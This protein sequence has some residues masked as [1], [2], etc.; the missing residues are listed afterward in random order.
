MVN[1]TQASAQMSIKSQTAAI[2]VL[3]VH[4]LQQIIPPHS[5]PS[6]HLNLQGMRP[7]TLKQPLPQ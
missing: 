7:A 1:M 2:T 3:T 6:F 5:Q 4:S